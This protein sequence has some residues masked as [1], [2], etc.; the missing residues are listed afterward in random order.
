MSSAALARALFKTGPGPDAGGV[1]PGP[2]VFD[3]SR[4]NC[5]TDAALCPKAG[6]ATIAANDANK[7]KFPQP[8]PMR[9]PFMV[10]P[11]RLSCSL[12]S[13]S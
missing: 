7:R 8:I 2:S 1:K 5:G 9:I 6:V 4:D 13:R 12:L 11:N 3:H 10:V